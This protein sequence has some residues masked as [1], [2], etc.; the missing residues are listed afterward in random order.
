[1]AINRIETA[2]GVRWRLRLYLGRDGD[3]KRRIYTATFDTKR[4]AER[5]RDRLRGVSRPSREPL[6]DYMAAWVEDVKAGELRPQTL[7]DY[8]RIVRRYLTDPPA[9]TPAVGRVPLNRLTTEDVQRL[10]AH[11]REVDGLAPRTIQYFH[12]VLRQGLTY[13]VNTGA[14][15]RNPTDVAKPPRRHQ[16][17]QEPEREK[18]RA[19]TEE[20]A[21][22]FLEAAR[23]RRLE[24]LWL[25]LVTGGLRPGE[26]LGLRWA[27]V[28]LEGGKLHVRRSLLR[29]GVEGWKLQPPKTKRARRTVVLPELATEA[30]RA[31]SSRQKRERLKA[32]GEYEDHGL[33]FTTHFGKPLHRTN[34]AR[35]DY[36]RVLEAAELGTYDGEGKGRRFVPGFRLYDLRHTCA[37]LLLLAGENPKVVSE[38]LGHAS[39]ALTLDTYSHVLPSMQEAAAEKLER[40][41]PA[42]G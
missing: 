10:Y 36:R 38:R 1:M 21:G 7:Y 16:A 17:G 25:V 28:D 22:R 20:E 24:A 23:G 8:R 14:L 18:I 26:A 40:M 15:A 33:V 32:G 31:W 41:F 30:L 6:G 11:L 2:G 9:G 29:R 4:E 37:T 5:E 27:D 39:I 42:T 3:G 35:R 13:A 34:L 12:A 19:M